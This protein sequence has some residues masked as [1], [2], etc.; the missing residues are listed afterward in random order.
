MLGQDRPRPPRY[1]AKPVP[2]LPQHLIDL[3]S[4]HHGSWRPSP[5]PQL[6]FSMAKCPPSSCTRC[7]GGSYGQGL[8]LPA[9][10]PCR[11]ESLWRGK[12]ILTIASLP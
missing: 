1:H 3:L 11:R 2:Q 12:G 9:V 4:P 7:S 5:P 6:F 8:T 10:S